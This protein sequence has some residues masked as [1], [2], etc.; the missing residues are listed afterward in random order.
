MTKTGYRTLGFAEAR[1]NPAGWRQ[2]GT[3]DKE[4]LRIRLEPE[5]ARTKLEGFRLQERERAITEALQDAPPPHVLALSAIRA[6]IFL[7]LMVPILWGG[8]G[9]LVMVCESLGLGAQKEAYALAATLLTVGA[10]DFF[11]Y[12]WFQGNRVWFSVAST[13]ISMVIAATLLLAFIR[14]DLLGVLAAQATGGADVNGQTVMS[15]I[16]SQIASYF[17][18]SGGLLRVAMP[19]LALSMELLAGAM[20][21]TALE[22]LLSPD[23]VAYIQRRGIRRRLSGALA[24][25][26]RIGLEPD[27]F[28]QEF[29]AGGVAAETGVPPAA[30]DPHYRLAIAIPIVLA[31]LLLLTMLVALAGA[32]PLS[33]RDGFPRVVILLDL[34]KSSQ[35][36]QFVENKVAAED[37][38]RKH[39]RPGIVID[40]YGITDASFS[41]PARLLHAR[42]GEDPGYFGEKLAAATKAILDTWRTTAA[43]LQPS[44]GRTDI[45]GALVVA[46]AEHP[47]TVFILSDMRDDGNG[48]DLSLSTFDPDK[49]M[50]RVS[51]RHL[52]ADLRGTDIHVLGVHALDR[53]VV[54]W[55]KLR[56][57][58]QA[59]F[60]RA[61]ARLLT[62]SQLRDVS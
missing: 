1:R 48:Y 60:D 19:L 22:R 5:L 16:P 9:F 38:I 56:S 27:L 20:L 31:V 51:Q 33:S 6:V 30:P 32:Q 55:T 8:Y 44:F 10:V 28:E 4:V 41:R 18:H 61:G 15:E 35:A 40:V 47:T 49:V 58:W 36:E 39:A 12:S 62:F 46:A 2:V 53:D 26:R 57:F 24:S 42:P 11:F 17:R 7:A 43:K 13:I 34:T 23:L 3:H 21:F 45:F 25:V 37:I 54:Y 29:L 52:V 50:T 14:A 59:Y